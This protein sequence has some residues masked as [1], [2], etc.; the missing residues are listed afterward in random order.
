MDSI[1]HTNFTQT[2]LHLESNNA[3]K[4]KSE[5]SNN[6][7]IRPSDNQKATAQ[8][9]P[10]DEVSISPEAAKK[11]L[12]EK[13]SESVDGSGSSKEKSIMEQAEEM[14]Q[15]M[16]DDIKERIDEITEKLQKL[17]A[18]SDEASKEQAK[19]LQGQLNDL[20]A[21]LLTIMTS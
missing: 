21:Q 15:K 14:K 17:E 3:A 19:L 12:D 18:Q 5:N 13:K 7:V 4:D 8:G 11:L 9:L 2:S 20:N 1:N 6:L 10:K 16:L